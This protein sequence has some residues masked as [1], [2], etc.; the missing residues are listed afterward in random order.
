MPITHSAPCPKSDRHEPGI[1]DRHAPD[2][3]IGMER[4]AQL[5]NNAHHLVLTGR[6]YRPQRRP[7]RPGAGDPLPSDAFEPG[8]S[9]GA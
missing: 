7:D 2:S 3:V 1:G 9:A 4:Y 6:S 8:E 5:I